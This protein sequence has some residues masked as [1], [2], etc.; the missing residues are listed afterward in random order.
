MT[1]IELMPETTALGTAAPAAEAGEVVLLQEISRRVLWL[2]AAIVDAGHPYVL[3]FSAG[4]RGAWIHCPGVCDRVRPVL[5]PDRRL[6]PAACRLHQ[7]DT[8]A[9]TDAALTMLGH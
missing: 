3:S 2:S 1:A 9:I 6:P 8:A 7:V 5:E 4:A